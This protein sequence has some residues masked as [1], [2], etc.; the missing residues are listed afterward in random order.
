[1]RYPKDED[2]SVCGVDGVR[3]VRLAVSDDHSVGSLRHHTNE[4]VVAHKCSIDIG[5][6]RR[7]Q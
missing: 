3:W 2:D 1:M 6:S 7:D 4:S 5:G